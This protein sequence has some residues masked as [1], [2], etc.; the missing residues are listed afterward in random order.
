MNLAAVLVV[1]LVLAAPIVGGADAPM[2]AGA[3]APEEL[4]DEVLTIFS[5]TDV[6][7]YLLF[8]IHGDPGEVLFMAT[9]SMSN[10]PGG[11]AATMWHD[12]EWIPIGD[13]SEFWTT[14]ALLAGRSI[15]GKVGNERFD[16]ASAGGPSVSDDPSPAASVRTFHSPGDALVL[17][18]YIAPAGD[19]EMLFSHGPGVEVVLRGEGQGTWF[20]KDDLAGDA[21]VFV[22][23]P[24]LFVPGV[25]AALAGEMSL[26]PPPAGFLRIVHVDF[27]SNQMSAGQGTLTIASAEGRM[28]QD[29]DSDPTGGTGTEGCICPVLLDVFAATQGRSVI[30]YEYAGMDLGGFNAVVLTF[31]VPMDAFDPAFIVTGP[32]H[33]LEV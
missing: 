17:V 10:T 26:G 30:E 15:H 3:D 33:E 32:R 21:S 24:S 7:G 8:D 1:A 29:L 9:W 11:F 16:D 5:A 20:D 23:S 18:G 6:A 25:G 12:G 28:R 27:I 13:P 14:Q 2:A 22:E 19:M 4:A 31:V